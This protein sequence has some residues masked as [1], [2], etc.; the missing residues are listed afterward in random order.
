MNK[1]FILLFATLALVIGCSSDKE[2]ELPAETPTAKELKIT[3]TL[4]DGWTKVEGS[5]L[6]HQYGKGT[7][8]FMIK[9]ESVLNKKDIDVAVSEAK[10]QV[11]DF[12]DNATLSETESLTIDG[13][14]AR[15]FTF[16]YAVNAAGMTIHM[17]AQQ[18]YVMID[19][20]CYM[21]FLGD[22]LS[23][24]DALSADFQAILAGIRFEI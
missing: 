1:H 14:D 23:T 2:N 13:V 20:K 15:S 12:F 18:V 17:K 7:A 4:P 19:E 22:M 9:N 8:S 16:T 5:V 21:I 24:Y 10:T 3:V 11:S 6:E